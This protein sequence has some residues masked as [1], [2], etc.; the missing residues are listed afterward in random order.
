MM[1]KESEPL[2]INSIT[3]FCKVLGHPKPKNPLL[4]VLEI[5]CNS[6]YPEL[7][8]NKLIYDFYSV[9]IKRNIKRPIRYGRRF[10]DFSEGTMGFSAPKQVFTLDSPEDVAEVTGWYLVFHADLIRKYQL[11]KRINDYN[12][13]SYSANEALHLSD[14]EEQTIEKIMRDIRKEYEQPIDLF[15]QDVIVSYLEVL[16]NYSNRFYNRQFITRKQA[17]EDLLATFTTYIR[18]Y[19]EQP[20]IAQ[21]PNV[22]DVAAQMNVSAH[23]LSDMLRSVTGQSAQQHI[24]DFLIEKAKQL[25]LTTNLSV[26]ETAYRLGFE[27]PQYFNR[28]FKNK[29]GITPA[30]FRGNN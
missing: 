5:K 16:L 27:Y 7:A 8:S 23:Y 24:H 13:F 29:T 2:V 15:S 10:Y 3:E 6:D 22:N 26:N 19:F 30:T 14:D 11:G 28:L 12:F 4:T 17:E 20:N 9:F 1:K 25:L 18:N 21:L